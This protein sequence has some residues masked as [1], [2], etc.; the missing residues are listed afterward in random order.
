MT[1]NQVE[2]KEFPVVA[3]DGG[4]ASGKSS[5]ARSLAA[6]RR[7]CHVDTGSHYRGLAL[8]LARAGVPAEDGPALEN[9]LSELSL[10][11]AFAGN[12][13][14]LCI[15]GSVP[16]EEEL[17]APRVNQSV[18]AYAAVPEVREALKA[19]QRD[20]VARAR[21]A[22]FQ[23]IVM[24]GRDIGTV[25]LPQADL[26]IFLTA[27]PE[28]RQLRRE[29]EGGRDRIEDRDRIDSGRSSAPLRPA[30]DAVII[31]NSGIGLEEVVHRIE[32]LLDRLPRA[33]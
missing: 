1:E 33:E 4:A 18:S 22:H 27:D 17:R 11:S 9:F 28:K 3:L 31:D 14:R 24:E 29:G 13:S 20:E 30:A 21:A 19:F 5:T 6:R 7:L 25:I 26:K 15:N 2:N 10:E 23:G 8:V 12:Q 32:D 16:A